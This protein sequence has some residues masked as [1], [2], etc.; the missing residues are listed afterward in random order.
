VL[1]R[2]LAL[3]VIAAAIAVP[4]GGARAQNAPEPAPAP[5]APAPPAPAPPAPAPAPEATVPDDPRFPD[6]IQ[7]PP[8]FEQDPAWSAYDGA[9]RAAAAGDLKGAKARLT[10]LASRWPGHPARSRVAALTARLAAR[11]DPNANSDVARGELA[12]WSTLGG[13]SFARS[14]CVAIDCS[15]DREDAGVY[16]L[17]IST[18]LAA[19]LLAS[20][21]GV[22]QAEVQ[23]YNSAQTWAS[24]NSLLVNDGFPDTR[25]EAS[26]AMAMQLGGLAAGIGLWQTWRPTHG[27]V[28][29]T[30][31]FLLWGTVLTT[32][33]YLIGDEEPSLRGVIIA[34][35]ASLLVGALVSQH[36]EMSRGR[37]LLIDV[38]GVLGTLVGGLI[39]VSADDET[40]AGVGLMLGTATGLVVAAG[41][42]SS[43]DAAPPVKVAPV[44]L[45]GP[46]R[47]K[48]HGISAGFSF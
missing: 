3:L 10:E 37:T 14:M 9:F 7:P 28:A 41:A 19:S 17:A 29:L 12:F 18:S 30:N 38:G 35:D 31:T 24:W 47:S 48:G 26:V 45:D 39:A 22:Q 6:V 4:G 20:R 15:S 13:V 1:A 46:G 23:L 32:W 33:G 8:G 11:H 43:W 34:G 36:V 5:P 2:A 44:V 42:S 21:H 27:D 16:T 25:E 40:G